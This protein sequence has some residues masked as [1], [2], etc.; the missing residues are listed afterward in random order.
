MSPWSRILHSPFSFFVFRDSAHSVYVRRSMRN[1]ETRDARM[2]GKRTVEHVTRPLTNRYVRRAVVGQLTRR[3][4][5]SGS[6]RGI[7]GE[8]GRDR[9][10]GIGMRNVER[11]RERDLYY[12]FCRPA[13]CAPSFLCAS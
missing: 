6:E 11:E 1:E 9:R 12:A 10:E 3:R 7:K 2:M 4:A 5:I 8:R 13:A